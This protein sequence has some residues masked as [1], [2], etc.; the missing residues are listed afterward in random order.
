MTNIGDFLT[1]VSMFLVIGVVIVLVVASI[2]S[3]LNNLERD[4]RIAN[5]EQVSSKTMQKIRQRE[6]QIGTYA[7]C[8]KLYQTLG[9][10]QKVEQMYRLIPTNNKLS[11]SEHALTTVAALSLM[12]ASS[13]YDIC[14]ENIK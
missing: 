8:A 2:P 12:D 4:K 5:S 6:A 14:E 1:K 11:E 13:A 3:Y 9:E 7:F 10:R